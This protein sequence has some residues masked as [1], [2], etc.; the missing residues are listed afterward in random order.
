M[1]TAGSALCFLL[2]GLFDSLKGSTI[3]ALIEEMG[4]NYSLG[5]TIVMGQYAGYFAATFLAGVLIDRCGHKASL[6][7]AGGCLL[8]GIA[9]YGAASNMPL[10]L[11]FIFLAGMGLGTFELT[12]S[13]IITVYYPE[14]KGRY[15][16][17]LTAV[18]GIG[19][20]FS[21][22]IVSAFFDRGFSW[23]TVYHAGL[24]LIV[25]AVLYFLFIK[26]PWKNVPQKTGKTGMKSESEKKSGEAIP[27]M[28]VSFLKPHFILMYAVNFLYMAAEMGMA[29]WMVEFYTKEKMYPAAAGAA[30]LSLFY[31]GMTAGR[32]IG[33]IFV[34]KLGRRKSV[35]LASAAAAACALA[36]VLGPAPLEIGVA[37]SGFFCSIIFP[38]STA[39][40]SELP[41]G[42]SGRIQGIYFASGGLGGMFGPWI[43]G[44]ASDCLGISFGMI[45]GSVFL[46]GIAVMIVLLQKNTG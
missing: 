32:V 37:L 6:V 28:Q 9:G 31:I 1:F 16:N 13:H 2:F 7:F 33:S 39:V 18:A 45:L 20:I 22:I 5:G 4:F 8:A 43:M 38:T 41:Q 34:D 44:G 36:G 15:L 23:R 19:A 29:T 3:S 40:I 30:L 27:G 35:F 21:P 10:L 12:G 24:V 11:F 14:K 26:S 25:P 42:D 46:L 17:I